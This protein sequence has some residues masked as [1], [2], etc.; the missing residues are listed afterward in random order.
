MRLSDHFYLYE[1][2]RSQLASRHG[3]ANHP[4]EPQIEA[5]RLLCRHALEPVRAHFKVPIR[6][7]S[8]FRCVALN[9]LLG[10]RDTSS[11]C[12]GEAVDFE[13]MGVANVQL[14]HWV[15]DNLQFDQLILEYLQADNPHGGWVHLS[16]RKHGNRAQCLTRD[17]NGYRR[18]LPHVPERF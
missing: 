18:G 10:S 9:R 4:S 1:F 2:T 7:S 13:L 3:L 11:H 15:A 5:L 8:G 12:S 16:Y 6:P 17:A 14:A